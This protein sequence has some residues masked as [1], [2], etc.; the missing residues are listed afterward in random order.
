MKVQDIMT[1]TVV[2]V[3]PTTRFKDAVELVLTRG[4]AGLPVV[5]LDGQLVGIVTA[6]DLLAKEAYPDRQPDP[7]KATPAIAATERRWT[8][9]ADGVTVEELMTT[10][11]VACLPGDDVHAVARRMLRNRVNQLPVVTDGKLIGIVSRRD[12]LSTFDR[13]DHDIAAEVRR[14]IDNS[15][16]IPQG[17]V[18]VAVVDG[19]VTLYGSVRYHNDTNAIVHIAANACGVVNVIDRLVS[20]DTRPEPITARSTPG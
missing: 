7:S 14:L 15:P 5:D 4:I 2:T 9:K 6:T 1:T 10:D 13:T 16:G 8:A 12:V 19:V 11:I 17:Y 3:T 18:R 20:Q